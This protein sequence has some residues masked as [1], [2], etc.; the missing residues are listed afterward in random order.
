MYPFEKNMRPFYNWAIALGCINF[1]AGCI[2]FQHNPWLG[3]LF[4]FLSPIMWWISGELFSAYQS[5]QKEAHT[6]PSYLPAQLCEYLNILYALDYNEKVTFTPKGFLIE[7][8][9]VSG[10]SAQIQD[11]IQDIIWRNLYPREKP[12]YPF[13]FGHCYVIK[14]HGEPPIY[15]WEYDFIL[16]RRRDVEFLLDIPKINFFIHKTG[17]S[18]GEICH[19]YSNNF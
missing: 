11:N 5:S 13:K 14:P 12:T 1:I 6:Y 3:Q 2:V 16:H 19:F 7:V 4:C 17:D 15:K 10:S 18:Y 9:Y 8:S